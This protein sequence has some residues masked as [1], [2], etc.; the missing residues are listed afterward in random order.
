MPSTALKRYVLDASVLVAI[1]NS[2]HDQHFSCYSFFRNINDNES[3]RWVV[4]GLIFFE[5]QATQSRLHR[6]RRSDQKVFRN[7]PLYYEN[8][9]IYHVTKNFLIK[10]N[11]LDLYNKFNLLRGQDLLYACI[12]HVEGIPLVTHDSDFDPYRDDL[13]LIKPKD[14]YGTGDKPLH[15]GFVSVKRN[16]KTYKV[17]Y[18]VFRGVVRLVTGQATHSDEAGASAIARLLLSEMIRSGLADKLNL[19]QRT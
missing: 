1:V 19:G 11:K 15:T 16:G 7:A 12:A 2:D 10:V 5:F 14:L 18:E 6:K 13:T 9:D 4:P 8:T 3:V 17:G